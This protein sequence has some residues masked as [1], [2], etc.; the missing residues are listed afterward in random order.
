[1]AVVEYAR[2]V[3]GLT[4]AN[5]TEVNP[6]TEY[7]VICLMRD[8]EEYLKKHQYGG[9][10][11]L[12]QW[13]SKIFNFQFSIFNQC[14]KQYRHFCK[15]YFNGKII[16]ERH[17][18]R[19]EFNNKYR[20]ILEKNGLKVVAVSPDGRLVEAIELPDHPFFIGTQFH[21]ELQ[22]RPLTPH[23][24]FLGFLKECLKMSH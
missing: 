24:L 2:N 10:I 9:T 15:D 7:P 13:P 6:K 23:P 18:H 21:P 19:Y 22:S 14:Y 20:K 3:C 17:R 12:G 5:S 8:Q 11:R 16:L 4:G 1:M